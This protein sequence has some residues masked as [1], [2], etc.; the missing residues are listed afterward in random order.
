M[1]KRRW[2]VKYAPGWYL[3]S[4]GKKIRGPLTSIINCELAAQR[5]NIDNPGLNL[6]VEYVKGEY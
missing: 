3:V 4:N 6:T 2:P 5:L 1:G